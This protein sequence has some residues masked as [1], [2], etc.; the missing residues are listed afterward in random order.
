MM[1]Q[2][3]ILD[4]EDE[5]GETEEEVIELIVQ[6]N[7]EEIR[8]DK[9]LANFLS[10]YSRTY[11][12]ALIED[13]K[14]FVANK[15]VKSSFK[16]S[17]GMKIRLHIPPLKE[18]EILPENL[19][20]DIL[21]EDDDI[22]L[23]NKPKNMVVHPSAGH[24]EGTLVNGLL[25]HCQKELSGI[26]GELRPGIVHR[27]DKDTTGVIVVCK[28][29]KSHRFI[30]EQLKEHSITRKYC[31]IV[32]GTF[33][34]E[35]GKIDAP[36]GRHPVDRKKMAI[37]HK[38]GKNA[39]THYK[40]LQNYVLKNGQGYA[41]VECQL[42]TGRTHQIRVHLSSI[43]HPLLGDEVYGTGKNPFHLVG[44]ALHAMILGF[45]HPKTGEY[46]EFKAELPEY[47]T[48]LLKKLDTM[49]K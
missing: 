47:F 21:Y 44:Q 31:A 5:I 11:L 20:L 34:E 41:L 25:F 8:I 32:H 18:V 26:N 3:N 36:I 17:N 42:E 48:E 38:N 46:A 28:N 2:D 13:G 43:G 29:D 22:I 19:F 45:L 37:N 15:P 12:K 4:Y 7:E 16:V 39:I 1:E 23:I 35:M 6:D 10:D 30:A 27:I 24:Y 40:V 14:V 49:S 9:Y 33:K